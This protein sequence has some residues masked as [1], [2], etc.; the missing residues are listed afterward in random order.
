MI[1][2]ITRRLT[3]GDAALRSIC[4]EAVGLFAKHCLPERETALPPAT[5]E[6]EGSAYSFREVDL[7]DRSSIGVLLMRPLFQRLSNQ[8]WSRACRCYI[9][10][11]T[12]SAAVQQAIAL[13]I[14]A[15]VENAPSSLLLTALSPLV[16]RLERALKGVH[17]KCR[18]LLLEALGSLTKA[19]GAAF[20]PLAEPLLTLA[21]PLLGNLQ[22]GAQSDWATRR[23]AAQLIESMATFVGPCLF[24]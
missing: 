22:S 16:S 9:V 14:R 20:E 21:L 15:A 10:A 1:Q 13:A 18:A 4:V 19:V 11:T 23:A 7:P 17:T 8:V 12:Q 24:S 6:S 2:I 5:G 3:C